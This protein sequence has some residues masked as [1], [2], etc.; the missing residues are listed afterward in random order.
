MKDDKAKDVDTTVYQFSQ[1]PESGEKYRV[2]IKSV[3]SLVAGGATFTSQNISEVFLTKPLPPEKLNVKDH[4]RQIFSWL[5][6]PTQSVK[7]YKLKIKK[8]TDK[9]TDYWIEVH[10]YT[11]QLRTLF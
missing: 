3:Y 1:L 10:D 8:D 7:H 2:T 5:K 6:S 4:E 11:N 9:A